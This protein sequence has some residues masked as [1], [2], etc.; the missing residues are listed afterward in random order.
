MANF[1]AKTFGAVVGTGK[2]N[3]ITIEDWHLWVFVSVSLAIYLTFYVLRSVG[4]YVLAKRQNMIR[5]YLA[6]IPYAWLFLLCKLVA[7]TRFM[8]SNFGKLALIATI[9]FGVS[10]ILT[11]I[12]YVLL[13]L[14]LVEYV[15]V[16]GQN[17][18]IPMGTE[19]VVSGLKDY[20]GMGV[21]VVED[22]YPYGTSWKAVSITLNVINAVSPIFDIL[23]IIITVS[24]YFAI[25]RKFWPQHFMLAALLSVFLDLFPI[26]IFVI[27][28]KSPVNFN[29]YM[30]SKYRN[31]GNP[32]GGQY[33]PY[34][35]NV[36]PFDENQGASNSQQEKTKDPGD[37]FDFDNNDKNKD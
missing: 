15:F 7:N 11:T 1:I 19:E 4:L 29:E 9:I 10:G 22:F 20:M 34:N 17:L 12:Y 25:F 35:P 24:L 18:Y 27:R 2:F 32:Y 26:F 37:P 36:N 14:P 3:I 16:H 30:R 33:N 8:G 31:Y 28:K 21:Y 6:F 5:A 13:T 23:S